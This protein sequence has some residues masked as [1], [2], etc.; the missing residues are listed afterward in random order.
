[1][2][3]SQ[4]ETWLF[5]RED[6][7][8]C[9]STQRLLQIRLFD[10]QHS[11]QLLIFDEKG[12]EVYNLQTSWLSIH[13]PE[14]VNFCIHRN[15]TYCVVWYRIKSETH[16]ENMLSLEL[17]HAE[18]EM[19]GNIV[20]VLKRNDSLKSFTIFSE[21][22]EVSI[23]NL[24]WNASVYIPT[25]KQC[26]SPNDA[27]LELQSELDDIQWANIYDMTGE[28]MRFTSEMTM[29]IARH[30]QYYVVAA[31]DNSK[32]KSYRVL[33]DGQ[34]VHVTNGPFYNPHGRSGI[35]RFVH[36]LLR[37]SMLTLASSASPTM[38]GANAIVRAAIIGLFLLYIA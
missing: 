4:Y 19:D 30:G 29:C 3:P 13:M 35:P 18:F 12:Q 2:L 7:E 16:T 17:K 23:L 38:H 5:Y 9:S 14:S 22:D 28:V 21:N 10:H 27:L 37:P 25:G 15:M 24:D 32:S 26:V 20:K 33:V 8:A 1:M 31:F 6:E 11:E 36:V 34:P